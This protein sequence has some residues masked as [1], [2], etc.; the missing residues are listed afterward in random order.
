M[1]NEDDWVKGWACREHDDEEELSKKLIAVFFRYLSSLQS[2]GVSKTTYRRHRSACLALGG[3]IICQ[4][5]SE[6]CDGP[7][8]DLDGEQ[9]L[10]KYIDNYGGPLVH[11]RDPS[12][13]RELDAM[14]KKLYKF[15]S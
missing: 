15:L 2:K 8:P 5:Y 10:G 9:I 1:L 6:E 12:W 4:V 14:C 11:S 13:Q 7:Y 3:Y